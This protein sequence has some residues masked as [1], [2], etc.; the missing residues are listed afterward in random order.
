MRADAQI[1]SS[2][3]CRFQK[4]SAFLSSF[5]QTSHPRESVVESATVDSV[6]REELRFRL[7]GSLLPNVGEERSK[8]SS[9]S[10]QSQEED[11]G[12]KKRP[13]DETAEAV[14]TVDPQQREQSKCVCVCVFARVRVSVCV[15]VC[16]PACVSLCALV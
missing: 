11:G 10:H 2:I 4:Q 13:A 9:L 5:P 16:A 15:C 6:R 12:T 1:V 14:P 7:G 8:L 3:S